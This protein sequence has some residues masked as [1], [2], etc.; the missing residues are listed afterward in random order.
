MSPTAHIQG[1]VRLLL[2]LAHRTPRVA[3]NATTVGHNS[4]TRPVQH[5]ET[6]IALSY[7]RTPC[8]WVCYSLETVVSTSSVNRGVCRASESVGRFFSA[9]SLFLKGPRHTI[10]L[11][12]SGLR[13]CMR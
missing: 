2:D 6:E 4:G 10:N 3:L 11:M 8:T 1:D 13:R 12:P 7:Y 9:S 5:V